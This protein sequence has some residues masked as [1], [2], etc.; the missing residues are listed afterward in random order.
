MVSV[1]DDA[2]MAFERRG[3]PL[4]DAFDS[5]FDEIVRM[6][7]LT[8]AE[9]RR[10][11]YRRIIG[12]S[13]P[14]IGLCHVLSGGI[15]RDLIRA[16]RQVVHAG[17]ALLAGDPVDYERWENGVEADRSVVM[18]Q[19]NESEPAVVELSDVCSSLIQDEAS[20]KARAIAHALGSPSMTGSDP[21]LHRVLYEVG[22]GTVGQTS[23][24]NVVDA[25]S[26]VTG[27]ESSGTARL[28]LDYAAYTYFCLTVLDVF[29]GPLDNERVVRCADDT[30]W[31]GSFDAL[32]AARHA[33]VIDSG[34]AWQAVS[35][36]RQAWGLD[37]LEFNVLE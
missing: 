22:Y 30:Q 16:A 24:A 31:P 2:L 21:S 20:R 37:V 11:L 3:I 29:T 13:E 32:A 7:R 23:L 36:F 8:Y 5:S 1:S 27:N 4:R 28:R 33:F 34:I 15:P 26:R 10:L 6:G 25:L 12:L 9:S 19:E 35:N 17:N 14:Y 18:L